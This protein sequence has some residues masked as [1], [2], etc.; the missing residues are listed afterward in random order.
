[1]K[2]LIQD[3]VKAGLDVGWEKKILGLEDKFAAGEQDAVLRDWC[4]G[5]SSQPTQHS[6]QKPGTAVSIEQ[7]KESLWKMVALGKFDRDWLELG[8]RLHAAAGKLEKTCDLLGWLARRFSSSEPRSLIFIIDLSLKLGLDVENAWALF[9][10]LL[11]HPSYSLCLHDYESIFHSFLRAGS[12]AYS[13]AVL[14]RAMHAFGRDVAHQPLLFGDLARK[15]HDICSDL[16][17][18][19]AVSM[20]IVKYLPNGMPTNLFYRSW[21]DHSAKNGDPRRVSLIIESI[22]EIERNPQPWHLDRLIQVWFEQSGNEYSGKA[23]DLARAMIKKR[24]ES[25]SNVSAVS[26]LVDSSASWLP[27]FIRRRMPSAGAYTFIQLMNQY[28]KQGHVKST[29][30]VLKLLM[31][32]TTLKLNS[33]MIRAI[34][35]THFIMDD[36]K[37]AWDFFSKVSQDEMYPI[38]LGTYHVLWR[39]LN[40]HLI[41]NPP[42]SKSIR[43]YPPPR[44]IFRQMVKYYLKDPGAC[45]PFE[46]R[47]SGPMYS[48]I[49][50]CF[51]LADDSVG[52]LMALHAMKYLFG[53]EPTQ[54]AMEFLVKNM[55]YRFFFRDRRRHNWVRN[56]RSDQHRLLEYRRAVSRMLR[57]VHADYQARKSSGGPQLGVTDDLAPGAISPSLDVLS[58]FMKKSLVQF[59]TP[60]LVKKAIVIAKEHMGLNLLGSTQSDQTLAHGQRS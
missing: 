38:D 56:K 50:H 55:A 7:W 44:K 29:H 2:V 9:L 19:D 32:S 34:L 47:P 43:R 28:A 21:L 48:R 8:I 12:V 20:H 42:G 46:E 26:S 54:K 58:T 52:A 1:M 4:R 49:I 53:Q 41:Q 36:V 5:I 57:A 30:T 35:A 15:L 24:V 25:S 6:T 13:T 23:E 27:R 51:C 22:F 37:G 39:G 33:S 14:C 40:Q 45:I 3:M 11:E 10:E 17:E 31:G 18:T 59:S 16:D 60:Q